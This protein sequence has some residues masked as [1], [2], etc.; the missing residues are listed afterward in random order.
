MAA[1]Q[2]SAADYQRALQALM[3]QGKVWPRDPDAVQAKV[4]AGL[5]VS[6]ERQNQRANNLLA[7]AFPA[8]AVELLPEWEATFGLPLGA[9][10]PN[11]LTAAR[12]ALVLVRFIGSLGVSVADLTQYAAL[13]GYS[14]AIATSAP[15]RCG[16]S[17]CGQHLGGEEQMFGLL[18]TAS[19]TPQMPFGT[20]GPAVLQEELVRVAPPFAALSFKFT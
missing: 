20:Y 15:F 14:I 16:Q 17:H 12:Q 9:A 3:P 2:Y 8:T 10:G 7:D 11:P 1:P 5:A 4:L 18:I 6:Y 19:A 13:L